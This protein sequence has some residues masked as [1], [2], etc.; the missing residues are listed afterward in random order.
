MLV[1]KFFDTKYGMFHD[2]SE[3]KWPFGVGLILAGVIVF[4]F[5]FRKS[6]GRSGNWM[7]KSCIKPFNRQNA[8]DLICP[9]CHN[10][11]EEL[12]GFYERYPELKT[13]D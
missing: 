10:E 9:I 12:E 6:K 7:C 8:P 4:V 5:S 3:I 11:L 2:F 13:R 1:P